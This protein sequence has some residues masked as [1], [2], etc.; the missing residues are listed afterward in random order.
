MDPN[1]TALNSYSD[2]RCIALY[3]LKEIAISDKAV[4]SIAVSYITY[5]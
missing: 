5:I 3:C 4:S 1:P 2:K